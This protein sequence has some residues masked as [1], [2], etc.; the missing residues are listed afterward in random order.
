MGIIRKEDADAIS[1]FSFGMESV[2]PAEAS[3]WSLSDSSSGVLPLPNAV[4]PLANAPE[5]VPTV[6]ELPEEV[7]P[8]PVVQPIFEVPEEILAGFYENVLQVGLED[9]KNQVFAEL[10]VLQERYA[11]ALDEL[12]AVG[13][14]LA[15]QNQVQVMTLSCMI[16]ERLL[17]DELKV[18]PEKLLELV[19]ESLTK[20]SGVDRVNVKCSPGDHEYLVQRRPSLEDGLGGGVTVRIELDETLEY[21]D[22]QLE[23]DSGII[24]GRV[25]ARIV[26]VKKSLME[27]PTNV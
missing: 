9:G 6:H 13:R 23:S 10:Q 3:E 1:S 18:R 24:D 19:K 27:Q 11:S 16:A 4:E 22:F 5:P 7:E 2:E 12:A 26:D 17:R 25:G 15:A 21:G 14:E 8:E 20:T